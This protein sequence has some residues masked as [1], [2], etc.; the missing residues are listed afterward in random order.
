M[1]NPQN[2]SNTRSQPKKHLLV[3]TLL[4]I[5]I[6]ITTTKTIIVNYYSYCSN[7]PGMVLLKCT[8]HIFGI[9]WCSLPIQQLLIAT[10]W[11]WHGLTKQRSCGCHRNHCGHRGK[12]KER[13]YTGNISFITKMMVASGYRS[14]PHVSVFTEKCHG[15]FDVIKL[16]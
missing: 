13:C 2:K 3:L 9:L 8:D 1:F 16:Q 12:T 5:I 11:Q 6:I 14:R 10:A 4:L 7:L 15:G